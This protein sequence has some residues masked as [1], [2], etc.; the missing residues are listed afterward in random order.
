VI[1]F[2]G[3][4]IR[5]EALTSEAR[6]LASRVWRAY[7]KQGGQRARIPV[8]SFIG[9]CGNLFPALRLIGPREV[10]PGAR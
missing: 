8:A 9:A 7:R 1:A 3:S 10:H 4:E 5:V 6:F 2:F